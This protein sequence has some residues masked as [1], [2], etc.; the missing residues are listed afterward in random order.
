MLAALSGAS[1]AAIVFLAQ[2]LDFG[3]LLTVVAAVPAGLYTL[4]ALPLVSLKIGKLFGQ[5]RWWHLLWFMVFLSGLTFRARSTEDLQENPLDPAS[6]YRVALVGTVGLVLLGAFFLRRHST[7][8]N[9]FK[10]PVIWLTA[11]ATVSALSAVW[12]VYPTWTLYKSVEYLTSV[13]LIAGVLGSVRKPCEFKTLFDWTWLLN[14]IILISAW[15]GGVYP[16]EESLLQGVGFQNLRIQGILPLVSRNGAGEVGALLGIVSFVRFLYSRR[17][18]RRFY[19]S[20]LAVAT[21]TMVL[22][23]SRWPITGFLVAILLILF[24]DKRISLL[25]LGTVTILLV[26]SLTPPGDTFIE[27][28]LR[29][30]SRELFLSLSGRVYWWQAALPL[31]EES[32]FL[33]HGAYAAGR[34]LVASE[35]DATL[36]SLHNT[37]IEVLI[38]TGIAGLLP[39]LAAVLWTWIILL[40]TQSATNTEDIL[41]QQLRLEAIGVLAL[42]T[43]GSIFS[44]SFIWHPP[45]GW[46]LILGYAECLRRYHAN[47]PRPQPLP[48]G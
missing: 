31:A 10:G 11:Y 43:V 5:L 37:W 17:L 13:V 25:A 22:S 44:V 45:L 48:T 32:I 24:L 34:F 16:P 8:D 7:I 19:L 23:H 9:L 15:F 28:F 42:L 4:P 47:R 30:Q 2:K 41:Q 21:M 18:F 35:F 29:S 20:T 27:F 1:S 3:L 6:I 39:L 40:R 33:G 12:S 26:I 38:G 36:S 46:L 14:G